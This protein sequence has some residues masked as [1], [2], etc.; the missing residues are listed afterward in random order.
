MKNTKEKICVGKQN[1]YDV[2]RTVWEDEGRYFVKTNNQLIEVYKVDYRF[3]FK[4]QIPESKEIIFSYNNVR[5]H[6]A[7]IRKLDGSERFIGRM[8][9]YEIYQIKSIFFDQFGFV[10]IKE[11]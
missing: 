1:G 7:V 5:C 8:D 6:A 4:H 11:V 2:Y 3:Y 10:A 9:G